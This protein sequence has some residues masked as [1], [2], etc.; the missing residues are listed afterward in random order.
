MDPTNDPVPPGTS[1][2]VCVPSG[3]EEE[4]EE[5]E[6]DKNELY[7]PGVGAS[8]GI[9]LQP[10]HLGPTRDS[11]D[12]RTAADGAACA[13]PAPRALLGFDSSA[14]QPGPHQCTEEEDDEDE[15][16]EDEDEDGQGL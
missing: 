2:G 1:E 7:L 11:V 14:D 4:E 8:R 6:E 15:E 5:E 9:H 13:T 16:D 12:G 10:D 3:E